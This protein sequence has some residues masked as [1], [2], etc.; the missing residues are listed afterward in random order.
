MLPR[1]LFSVAKQNVEQ[2]RIHTGQITV[3]TVYLKRLTVSIKA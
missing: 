3:K 2:Y 1:A